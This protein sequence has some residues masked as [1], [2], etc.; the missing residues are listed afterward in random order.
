M[1]HSQAPH[2]EGWGKAESPLRQEVTTIVQ[3]TEGTEEKRKNN[4]GHC[5]SGSSANHLVAGVSG[6]GITMNLLGFLGK[7]VVES[8]DF[9]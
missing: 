5:S 8:G 4:K 1:L 7:S 2:K 6:C 3:V 9:C